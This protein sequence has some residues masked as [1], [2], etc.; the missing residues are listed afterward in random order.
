MNHKGH[1]IAFLDCFS[2][3]SGDMLLGAL[4]SAGLPLAHL[5]ENLAL[6]RLDGFELEAQQ[7]KNNSITGTKIKVTEHGEHPHRSWTTIRKLIEQSTLNSQ[8]KD[9]AIKVFGLLAAAEAKVHGCPVEEVHFHEVGATDSIVDIVGTAVGFH[10]LGIES[11][12]CSPLPM[13]SGWVQCEHG[14]LPL[15]APAVCEL[16]KDT[17]VYGVELQ[18][19]LVT[20]TGAAIAKALSHAYGSMPPMLIDSIG[21]GAGSRKL[22]N[23][24][25]NLLRLVVGK[26]RSAVETQ[27][28]EVIETHIDDWAAE[29]FPYLCER[30]FKLSALDVALIPI[31]M[32]KG[33]PGYLLR[34]VADPAHAFD[35][36]RCIFSETTAIGLRYRKEDRWTLPRQTGFVD[37][38]FGRLKVKKTETPTGV[39]LS[40][41]YED[42]K[43]LA[44]KKQVPLKKVYAEINRCNPADFIAAEDGDG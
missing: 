27:Q 38:K 5:R 9:N 24:Q 32:K 11:I 33:R 29:G 2:G 20:P 19:E 25:P 28:V 15:P 34:V 4:L 36:K 17:P 3:I 35:L 1:T 23:G 13:P 43:D 16:L 12:T 6:L 21:Y 39:V 10:Y 18:Q 7:T 40:P 8:V 22:A 31:L 42:C 44:D 14:M 30:L 41:E 26:T 37:T